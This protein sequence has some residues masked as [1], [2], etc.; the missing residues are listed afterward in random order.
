VL[1]AKGR[2]GRCG[3]EVIIRLHNPRSVSDRDIRTATLP[4]EEKRELNFKKYR[5]AKKAPRSLHSPGS[6]RTEA[7]TRSA[8]GERK[9]LER[10]SPLRRTTPNRKSNRY[11][12]LKHQGRSLGEAGKLQSLLLRRA[13]TKG[14]SNRRRQSLKRVLQRKGFDSLFLTE[15]KKENPA[16]PA[17][18]ALP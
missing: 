13:W 9:A 11:S 2:K 4:K 18:C 3:K 10:S 7:K 5:L 1:S 12:L 17:Q 8:K 15:T 14:R 6:S 16:S